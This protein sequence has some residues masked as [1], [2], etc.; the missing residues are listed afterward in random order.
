MSMLD[1]VDLTKKYNK[2]VLVDEDLLKE[3]E[4]NKE[5]F[6]EEI[7]NFKFT[8][9]SCVNEIEYVKKVFKPENLA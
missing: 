4:L 8:M 5:K 6:D 1:L 2:K 7:R 3:A 9:N